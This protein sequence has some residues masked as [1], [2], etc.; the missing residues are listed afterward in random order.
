MISSNS[1][2]DCVATCWFIPTTTVQFHY[3]NNHPQSENDSNS[4][5]NKED[6]TMTVALAMSG[7]AT[8][9]KRCLACLFSDAQVAKEM[10]VNV[11]YKPMIMLLWN[12]QRVS[13]V[14][15]KIIIKQLHR[16]VGLVR[17][18]LFLSCCVQVWEQ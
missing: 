8:I 7:T 17:K 2:G 6:E 10:D 3:Y 5:N 18:Y 14:Y 12:F 11:H 4:N 9:W 15:D 13:K 1:G 16:F